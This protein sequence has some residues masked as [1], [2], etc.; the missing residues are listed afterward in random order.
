MAPAAVTG[1]A[2]A[3]LVVI[4][5][6]RGV[7][8]IRLR[9]RA[10]DERR[11]PLDIAGC[12][13]H[14]LRLRLRRLIRL[15]AVRLVLLR[16]MLRAALIIGIRLLTA[17]RLRLLARRIGRLLVVVVSLLAAKVRLALCGLALRRLT[18]PGLTTFII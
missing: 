10:G 6:R 1:E 7:L 15:R 9:L 14:R 18:L 2:V 5:V 11:Q 16:L 17:V 4:A 8:R 3:A 13:G 12:G